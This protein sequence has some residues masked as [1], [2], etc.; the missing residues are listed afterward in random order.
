MNLL[1]VF[2]L[3]NIN[4]IVERSDAR[5]ESRETSLQSKNKWWNKCGSVSV[6]LVKNVDAARC[7][8]VVRDL[9]KM[10]SLQPANKNEF[11]G[12]KVFRVVRV[13][14]CNRTYAR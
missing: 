3:T 5:T 11:P 2:V 8:S 9:E 1:E 10:S 12:R 4:L 14:K 7:I 13:E 6:P